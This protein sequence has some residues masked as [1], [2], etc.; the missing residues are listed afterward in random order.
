M[1]QAKQF[2]EFV[3]V[4]ED[5]YDY[6]KF[7]YGS[8]NEKTG[9]FL[10]V[11]GSNYAIFDFDP[12]HKTQQERECWFNNFLKAIIGD[13]GNDCLK[14]VK[15]C[16][17]GAHV[18]TRWDKSIE[19]DET[20]NRYVKIFKSKHFDIDLFIPEPV[21]KSS[22]I[23]LPGTVAKIKKEKGDGFGTYEQV[24][25]CDEDS[26]MHMNTFMDL[27][28]MIMSDYN[29]SF[30]VQRKEVKKV[31]VANIPDDLLKTD[32][33]IKLEKSNS[34][35]KMENIK[36][37]VEPKKSEITES[38][39][40]INIMSFRKPKQEVGTKKIHQVE[41]V[42]S[43]EWAR[44][45]TKERMSDECFAKIVIG[46]IAG[47]ENEDLDGPLIHKDTPDA[48]NIINEISLMPLIKGFNALVKVGIS[49]DNIEQALNMI[50]EDGNLTSNA[51][52]HWDELY[53]KHKDEMNVHYGVLK[54]MLKFNNRE[55][56][57]KN[58]VPLL[59]DP[60]PEISFEDTFT[61]RDMFEHE[62]YI[63]KM[64]DENGNEVERVNHKKCVFDLRRILVYIPKTRG[65]IYCLKDDNDILG[66]F[67]IVIINNKKQLYDTLGEILIKKDGRKTI[68]MATIFK[69]LADKT[70]FIRDAAKFYTKNSKEFSLWRGWA[71][72]PL[73]DDEAY[74][75]ELVN[76]W[77]HHIKNVWC[78]RRNENGGLERGNVDKRM[79]RYLKG[80][81]SFYVQHPGSLSGNILL[82][83]GSQ[84]CGKNYVTDQLCALMGDHADPNMSDIEQI[85]KQFNG[86]LA[87]RHLII[88]NEISEDTAECQKTMNKLKAYSTQK[89]VG[90]RD[91]YQSYRI[92]ENVANFIII[93]NHHVPIMIEQGDRRI[94]AIETNDMFTNNKK[95]FKEL[96]D[97]TKDPRFYSHLLTYLL[98]R[99]LN[100]KDENGELMFNPF[101]I[102]QSDYKAAITYQSSISS[103]V[104]K[105]ADKFYPDGDYKGYS[106]GDVYKDFCKYV[107]KKKFKEQNYETFR[108]N[109][110]AYCVFKDERKN[111][112]RNKYFIIKED[113]R[114][115]FPKINDKP[116]ESI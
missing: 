68:T 36:T 55:Y 83:T 103:F 5:L 63:L 108:R 95:Y 20:K 113:K 91:L 58:I 94:V 79:Y 75:K 42:D 59:P 76:T 34:K 48:N 54:T 32:A 102:P 31:L 2:S 89:T 30:N 43:L 66:G 93:S 10:R 52:A 37:R 82:I 13:L 104:K 77:K 112:T 86:A 96:W 40:V 11:N 6:Q 16:S 61:F 53:N 81:F 62:R 3:G 80:L 84:G 8:G 17:C 98:R 23:V 114:E 38:K 4:I 74:D 29:I 99:D 24:L 92:G 26:L 70:P 67:T 22:I 107:D 51:K 44:Y 97:A 64:K 100:K 28:Q 72:N 115:D 57:D 110:L 33:E 101:D 39:P 60:I 116:L 47:G 14:V 87:G 69:D 65:S 49:K 111:G 12:K 78:T 88:L 50:R 18:Y 19:L 15:T 105:N 41:E 90:I 106:D 9:R 1:N 45:S 85:T 7:S 27:L 71:Y 35:I 73:K 21:E 46:F 25:D 109:L 56:Y